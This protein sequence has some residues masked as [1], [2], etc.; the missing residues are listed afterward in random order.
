[1]EHSLPFTLAWDESLDIGSDT[2]TGVN[3]ADYLPP[4]T[5]TGKLNKLTLKI[6]RPE[7]TQADIEKL[8]QAQQAIESGKE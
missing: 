8:K 7:L 3:D 4:F 6:D 1:M 5:F 2:L